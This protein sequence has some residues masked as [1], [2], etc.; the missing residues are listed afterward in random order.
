A[1]AVAPVEALGTL[2]LCHQ[3]QAKTWSQGPVAM[4]HEDIYILMHRHVIICIPCCRFFWGAS[5]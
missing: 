4:E 3:D 1:G 5:V 2:V